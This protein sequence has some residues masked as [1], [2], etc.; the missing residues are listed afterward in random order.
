MVKLATYKELMAGNPSKV[1]GETL[2]VVDPVGNI[3]EELPI[4]DPNMSFA[5]KAYPTGNVKVAS[6]SNKITIEPKEDPF[7]P[8]FLLTQEKAEKV[9]GG[10][11]K[12]SLKKRRKTKRKGAG[13][14]KRKKS[15]S[16]PEYPISSIRYINNTNQGR[17][18]PADRL[19]ANYHLWD[20]KTEQKQ[21]ISDSDSPVTKGLKKARINKELN[22]I[23]P[24]SPDNSPI[25]SA[26]QSPII[27]QEDWS[28]VAKMLKEKSPEKP[29]GNVINLDQVTEA[30]M[31]LQ[32]ERERRGQGSKRAMKMFREA[33]KGGRKS[34]KKT[35]RK[36]GMN[37]LR[38]RQ[39]IENRKTKKTYTPNS[40][41]FLAEDNRRKQ[42]Q[43]RRKQEEERRK[44]EQ[45]E[46]R[47]KQFTKQLVAPI[48]I[49]RSATVEQLSRLEEEQ[50][51][52]ERLMEANKKIRKN[53]ERTKK[54]NEERE[55][56]EKEIERIQEEIESLNGGR[57]KSLKKRRKTKR[58]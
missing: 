29:Q 7:D 23:P 8:K 25:Q 47:R 13:P 35:K 2:E 3:E 42:E 12:K 53:Q 21:P 27:T 15:V 17:V 48:P 57:R 54:A 18:D 51:M 14:K 10:S 24:P 56:V 11:R 26:V 28:Q 58:I 16:I 37:L 22:R 55:K 44:Q 43:E 52:L 6:H 1:M 38:K 33:K 30:Q 34:L 4:T 19:T 36:G 46:E 9:K 39:E 50:I 20:L 49:R 40:S 45:E 5:R 31:M 32:A 41:T